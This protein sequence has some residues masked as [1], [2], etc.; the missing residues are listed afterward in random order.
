VNQLTEP[1]IYEVKRQVNK[2]SCQPFINKWVFCDIKFLGLEYLLFCGYLLLFT[3]LITRVRFF[4]NSGLSNS[5]LI[6]I[7]FIKILAGIFYGWFGIYYS[8]LAQMWDTW[9]FHYQGLQEFQLL[10]TNPHE[11]FTNLFHDPYEGGFLKF[12]GNTDSYWND[13]KGNAFI[14]LLSIFDIFSFGHYYINVIFYS[15]I[16][17]FGP[18]AVYRVMINEFPGRKVQVALAAFL[19]PSFLYWTSGIHKDGL[20]FLGISLVI[21]HTYFAI[22]NKKKI[23]THI[24]IALL[25]LFLILLMRNFLIV[26]ILPA[27]LAW[28]IASA[29][30][31]N[32]LLTF[33]VIYSF[34]I[35]VFFNL[36]YLNTNLDFPQAVVNK[37][38]AFLELQGGSA[39]PIR[40]LKPT[41]KSFLFSTPQAI[42]LSTLRP[43][44][45]DIKNLPS[46]AAAAETFFFLV[47]LIIYLFAKYPVVKSKT[48]I[49]FCLFFSF[50]VLLTIGYTV[51]FLGAIVRYRSII[52]PFLIVPLA[53]QIDWGAIKRLNIFNIINKINIKN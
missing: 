28:I 50:S 7:F 21:Y 6:I 12:F 14:K 11:Y 36:R 4:K 19:I 29:F 27:V 26:N 47:L 45:G 44:P 15:L 34:F 20:V 31:K 39:V 10:K 35:L 5:Q 40:E 52:L 38:Q 53:A 30:K 24:L 3:W 41:A 23:G 32:R 9:S 17:M 48:F 22:K 8:G 2:L 16:T 18:V 49:Y 51:N 1:Q 43:Y 13:L 42:S 25:G 33:V 46:L 37:Q